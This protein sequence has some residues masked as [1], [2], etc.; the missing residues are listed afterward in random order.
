VWRRESILFDLQRRIPDFVF[1][2]L[3]LSEIVFRRNLLDSTEFPNQLIGVELHFCLAAT[4]EF[5]FDTRLV[6]ALCAFLAADQSLGQ[7]N[8]KLFAGLVGPDDFNG[9]L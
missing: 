8:R 6:L 9:L 5:V 2:E 3:D 7:H 1:C 4:F